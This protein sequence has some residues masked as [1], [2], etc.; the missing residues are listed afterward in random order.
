MDAYSF[1][2]RKFRPGM[3]WFAMH[4]LITNFVIS[5][6]PLI[7]GLI[8]QILALNAVVL[9]A[10]LMTSRHLPWR[11]NLANALEVGVLGCILMCCPLSA[12][13]ADGKMD[14][15]A[16][17]WITTVLLI[18]TLITMPVVASWAVYNKY[19]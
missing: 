13:L 16:V 5:L 19:V 2:L 15:E 10:V 14:T 8:F 18:I 1:L 12:F 11:V 7:P 4:I 6:L 17:A 9:N 3:S